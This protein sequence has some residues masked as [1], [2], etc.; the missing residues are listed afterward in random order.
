MIL[1]EIKKL[2]KSRGVIFSGIIFLILI[3]VMYFI[4]PKDTDYLQGYLAF[5]TTHPLFLSL[6]LI[7]S[8]GI[9][10]GIYTEEI[11]SKTDA[12]ILSSKE[13][14]DTICAKGVLSIIIP[15]L[16]YIT[17]TLIFF[18]IGL[19]KSNI[20]FE[21]IWRVGFGFL[22][23]MNFSTISFFASI[24][25]KNN[26]EALFKTILFLVASKI[27]GLIKQLGIFSFLVS[28]FSYTDL[29]FY[30]QGSNMDMKFMNVTFGQIYVSILFI[31]LILGNY[32]SYKKSLNMRINR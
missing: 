13:K 1:W 2:F 21:D 3:F 26:L 15:S 14:E 18:I 32:V 12:L 16:L 6:M 24:T 29:I 28:M 22:L 30:G 11:E 8:M 10:C 31:I 9:F 5:K 20:L 7:I 23:V 27:I 25:S 4:N 19:H 17:Y